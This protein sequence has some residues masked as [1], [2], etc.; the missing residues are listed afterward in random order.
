MYG[1]DEIAEVSKNLTIDI[2]LKIILLGHKNNCMEYSNWLLNCQNFL[3]HCSLCL[4]FLP[5]LIYLI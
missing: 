4:K 1:K 3:Q 5:N 2:D